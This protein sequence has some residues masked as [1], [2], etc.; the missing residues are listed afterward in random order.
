[1][2]GKLWASD[3]QEMEPRGGGDEAIASVNNGN[4]AMKQKA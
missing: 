4:H 3:P 1:M 2:I